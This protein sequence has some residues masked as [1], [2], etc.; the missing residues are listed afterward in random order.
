MSVL[1]TPRALMFQKF[2]ASDGRAK[3]GT[4]FRVMRLTVFEREATVEAKLTE[5][6]S[7]F[8][9]FRLG[10]SRYG[11]REFGFLFVCRTFCFFFVIP[12][13]LETYG[14]KYVPK[15]DCCPQFGLGEFFQSI[16]R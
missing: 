7:H 5:W 1:A 14:A 15:R 16:W 13:I 4:A 12:D 8:G 11:W 3:L 10:I 9:G 2:R 6:A